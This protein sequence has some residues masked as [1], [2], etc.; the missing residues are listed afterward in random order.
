MY[1]IVHCC[2][3]TVIVHCVT[4]AETHFQLFVHYFVVHSVHLEGVG[5]CEEAV[6]QNKH[7]YVTCYIERTCTFLY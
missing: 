5:S 3:S 6:W 2:V 1:R 4:I 7:K